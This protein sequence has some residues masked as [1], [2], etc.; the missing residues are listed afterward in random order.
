MG[1]IVS[2][3]ALTIT[4]VGENAVAKVA[5]VIEG[6]I[7]DSSSGQ[8]YL[9]VCRLIGDDT[10]GDGIDDVIS[11]GEMLRTTTILGPH[12]RIE[13]ALTITLPAINLDE[14]RGGNFLETDEIRALVTLTPLLPTSQRK[15][16]NLVLF[17]EQTTHL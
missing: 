6:D 16:S 3:V 9:E 1:K 4:R 8:T 14:D 2:A 10:P 12:T 5:Y 11:R 17:N 7:E 13:R 15:E